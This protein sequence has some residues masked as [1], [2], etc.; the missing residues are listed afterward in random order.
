MPF[1]AELLIFAHNF[2][3]D[4]TLWLRTIRYRTREIIHFPI[5]L[6]CTD[7]IVSGFVLH[8][9]S[10]S[11]SLSDEL[12]KV[13]AQSAAL[14]P[15]D[16][17]DGCGRRMRPTDAADG[18]GRRIGVISA[19]TRKIGR[20]RPTVRS[21]CGRR[22]A[23]GYER[24]NAFLAFITNAADARPTHYD[25]HSRPQ[26]VGRNARPTLRTSGRL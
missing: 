16:A 2:I 25:V 6:K 1:A 10:Q 20:M 8:I 13:G 5:F 4:Q 19:I 18:C 15:T 26:C 3:A 9:L 12:L 14:R 23:A 7:C 17:A 11:S 21:T 22:N 24:R